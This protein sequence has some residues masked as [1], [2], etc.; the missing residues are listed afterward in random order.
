MDSLKTAGRKLVISALTVF[1][2]YTLTSCA[3]ILGHGKEVPGKSSGRTSAAAA[4]RSGNV[5]S[6]REKLVEAADR[7]KGAS[8]LTV[9]GK[10]FAMDCSGLVAALYYYAGIDLQSYFPAYTG[11]GTERIYK[12]LDDRGLLH[13]SWQPEPGDI[14][15]WDNTYDRN[16]NRKADDYLTHTGMVVSSDT[17]GNIVYI[18]YNYA[19]GIVYENMNLRYKNNHTR[20][21]SGKEIIL[22]S[23]LR[24]KGSPDIAAGTLSGQLL[25]IF[26]SG[27]YLD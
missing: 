14:I 9:R 26:G 2:I 15:F 25:R 6:A 21:V 24:Q 7:Y 1:M 10:K 3:S 5:S 17:S 11:S 16:N 13:K 19:R 22:N 12:A 18:H 4:G 23:H 27:V 8:S 20:I